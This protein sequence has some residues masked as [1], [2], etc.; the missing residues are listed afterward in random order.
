MLKRA[1]NMKSKKQ[2]RKK[3]SGEL[4]NWEKY[5]FDLNCL[6]ALFWCVCLC[7]EYSRLNR[8]I[9]ICSKNIKIMNPDIIRRSPGFLLKYPSQQQRNCEDINPFS[10]GEKIHT[11]FCL[12]SFSSLFLQPCFN[13]S[14]PFHLVYVNEP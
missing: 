10:K 5:T 4:E 12:F 2:Q 14:E 1:Q 6:Y 7:V 3:C 9:L 11:N 13:S 8:V